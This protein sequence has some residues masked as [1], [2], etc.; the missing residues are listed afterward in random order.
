MQNVRRHGWKCWLRLI[1]GQSCV[2][3]SLSYRHAWDNIDAYGIPNPIW[4]S[5]NPW[6]TFSM[7]IRAWSS[8]RLRSADRTANWFLSLSREVWDLSNAA[9]SSLIRSSLTFRN[10][11]LAK[12]RR[13]FA[14]DLPTINY[15]LTDIASFRR[16]FCVSMEIRLDSKC[17]DSLIWSSW[18][19]SSW[20]C[21][22]NTSDSNSDWRATA[23]EITSPS[24]SF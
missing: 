7:S 13:K 14:L 16:R 9:L 10:K 11:T 19:C 12:V 15:F 5:V 17:F 20:V 1:S 24:W 4:F 21:N 3:S 8:A 23:C 6:D 18:F 22:P 2:R